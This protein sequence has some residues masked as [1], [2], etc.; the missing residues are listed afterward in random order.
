MNRYIL[1]NCFETVLNMF[2]IIL[3]LDI[4]MLMVYGL[5]L[6]LIKVN[7]LLLCEHRDIKY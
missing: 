6:R 2:L 1:R 3:M 4:R 7:G 5:M